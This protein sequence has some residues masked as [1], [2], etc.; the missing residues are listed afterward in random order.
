[1]TGYGIPRGGSP[2]GFALSDPKV[3]GPVRLGVET[4]IFVFG[5]GAHQAAPPAAC[6]FSHKMQ[7]DSLYLV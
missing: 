4:E 6:A 3:L 5:V 1:M 7:S 2:G